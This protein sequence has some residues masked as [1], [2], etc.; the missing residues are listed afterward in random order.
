[1]VGGVVALVMV[2]A[3]VSGAVQVRALAAEVIAFCSWVKHST[4]KVLLITQVCTEM[5][6][7][8]L[9]AGDNPEM[10]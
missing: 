5:A 8:K 6:V 1:M 2:S 7:G 9:N 3:F 4:L 10:N